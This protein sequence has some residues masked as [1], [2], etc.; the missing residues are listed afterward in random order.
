VVK[1]I[2]LRKQHSGCEKVG[3]SEKSSEVLKIQREGKV[4]AEEGPIESQNLLFS[5]QP[6]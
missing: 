3:N 4:G 5:L 6:S 2:E 1:T